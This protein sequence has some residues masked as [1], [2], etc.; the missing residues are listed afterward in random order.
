MINPSNISIPE[1]NI[2]YEHSIPN[3]GEDSVQS[4]TNANE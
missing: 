4:L 2:E 3:I 1:V